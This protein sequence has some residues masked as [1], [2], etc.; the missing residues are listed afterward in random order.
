MLVFI[1]KF[2]LEQ[3]DTEIYIHL[4]ILIVFIYG[5]IKP[6]FKS[7]RN[8]K[9]NITHFS[10]KSLLQFLLLCIVND[11]NPELCK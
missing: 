7:T 10:C 4:Q 3:L 8:S 1:L 2:F 11:D 9:D 5:K 6:K